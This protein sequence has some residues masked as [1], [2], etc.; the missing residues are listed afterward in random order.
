MEI[1]LQL[2]AESHSSENLIILGA[3]SKTVTTGKGKSA[4]NTRKSDK[5]R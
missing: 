2:N 1:K 4:K 5:I 3:F